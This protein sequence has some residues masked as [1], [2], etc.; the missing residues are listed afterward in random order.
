MAIE[1][2][3]PRS[4]VIPFPGA[5]QPR[6]RSIWRGVASLREMRIAAQE[7][8]EQVFNWAAGM[9][10]LEVYHHVDGSHPRLLTTSDDGELE[11]L[12]V[13]N[14]A[15]PN[16]RPGFKVV[17]AVAPNTCQTRIASRLRDHMSARC[18]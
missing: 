16:P 13:M 11:L 2:V 9:A 1:S 14:P 10:W 8:D 15:T 17:C 6:P 7:D 4:N 5:L 12:D 3:A 18:G